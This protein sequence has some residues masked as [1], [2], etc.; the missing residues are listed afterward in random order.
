MVDICPEWKKPPKAAEYLGS[1]N[2]GLGF[3]HVDVEGTEEKFKA[4][5]NL[6]NCRVLTIEEGEMEKEDI[7]QCLR[8]MFDKEW[9]WNLNAI[10]EY[11]Y[12]IRSP[13]HQESR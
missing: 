2:H 1:A 12:M 9:K 6:D 11:R 5:S 4:W 13:P 7:I 3:L 10:D 8:R